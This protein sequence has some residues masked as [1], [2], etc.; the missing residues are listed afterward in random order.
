MQSL[1]RKRTKNAGCQVTHYL[2][3]PVL[4]YKILFSKLKLNDE[5]KNKKNSNRSCNK[6]NTVLFFFNSCFCEALAVQPQKKAK[7]ALFA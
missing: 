3:C 7:A 6:A 1:C 2:N 4:P 5:N